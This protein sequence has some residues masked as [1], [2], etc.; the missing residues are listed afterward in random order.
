MPR[1]DKQR[2]LPAL[3]NKPKFKCGF[4]DSGA[5]LADSLVGN[6]GEYSVFSLFSGC[7]GLDFGFKGGFSVLGK[8]Y[9][10]LPFHVLGAYD[11]LQDA[12]DCYRLNIDDCIASADL[13]KVKPCDLPAADM[14]MGGFPCQDFSS[15]GPKT[16]LDGKRGQ[17]YQVLIN[18]MKF[19]RPRVVIGENVIHL[20]RMQDGACLR[21]IVADFESVGYHFDVWNLYAPDYGVPQNRRR[22]IFAGVRND[23]DGFPV[24]PKPTNADRH[25]TI[26]EALSDLEGITDETVPN[27]SPYFV[28]TRATSGGGQG[29]KSADSKRQNADLRF[30]ARSYQIGHVTVVAVLSSQV[31]ETVIARYQGAG[32]LVL[33]GTPSPDPTASTFA[34]FKEVIGYNLD[35]FFR[36]SSPVVKSVIHDL[37][38]KLLAPQ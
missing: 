9:G 6:A 17:L 30:G 22:L 29:Y 33:T 23:I 34:F 27:Q 7:G 25:V 3:R 14:L 28:A 10:R 15:A 35:D 18:Y 19:H 1:K 8:R 24:A 21:Q 38:G 26:S 5:A 20:A 12:V 16:G 31:S 37:I 36:R 4:R 2:K 13:T 32:M 11:L